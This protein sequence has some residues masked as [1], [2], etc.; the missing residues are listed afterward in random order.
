MSIQ[1]LGSIGEFISSIAVIVSLVYLAIQVRHNTAQLHEN[2]KALR[3]NEYNTLMGNWSDLRGHLMSDGSLA[4]IMV[5]SRKDPDS[6]DPAERERWVAL[7]TETLFINYHLWLRVQ[8]GI[9]QPA[10]WM[11]ARQAVVQTLRTPEGWR[12]WE[13]VKYVFDPAFIE[14]LEQD[15]ELTASSTLAEPVQE[16]GR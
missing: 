4:D 3:R 15:V 16:D 8:D 7:T 6:L 11:R 9:F 2:E 1:D 13:S 10:Q 14:D 5:R 12:V